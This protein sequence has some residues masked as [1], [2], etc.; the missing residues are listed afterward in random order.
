MFIGIDSNDIS[1]MEAVGC[2][3]AVADA[4]PEVD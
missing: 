1:A 2:P 3:V 4:Y